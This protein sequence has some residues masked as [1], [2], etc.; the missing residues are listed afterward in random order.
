MRDPQLIPQWT[1]MLLDQ[2][3]IETVVSGRDRRMGGEH[4]LPR[5]L[6]NASSND[7]PSSCIRS[8]TASSG[9][10]ALCPSFK[11]YTPA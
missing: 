11:W 6:R 2:T 3:R 1:Q 4:R 9:A 5:H 10:K 7:N 8:R